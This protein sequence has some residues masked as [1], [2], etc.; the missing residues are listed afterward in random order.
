M[1]DSHSRRDATMSGDDAV[2]PI[3]QNRIG[4]AE[5]LDAFGDLL[6]LFSTVGPCVSVVRFQSGDRKIGD[7]EIATR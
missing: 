5:F 4:E 3:E 6:D 2:L 1:R 7:R